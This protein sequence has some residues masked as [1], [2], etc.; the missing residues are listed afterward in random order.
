MFKNI[1]Y[2]K[3]I[4]ISFSSFII[5]LISVITLDKLYKSSLQEIQKVKFQY[6]ESKGLANDLLIYSEKVNSLANYYYIKKN[7]EHLRYFYILIR[8]F[9]NEEKLDFSLY[10]LYY[11]LNEG[12]ENIFSGSSYK[13]KDKLFS[14]DKISNQTRRYLINYYY[15]TYNYL[16]NIHN[17]VLS[18][19]YDNDSI[20]LH[21]HSRILKLD[22]L[23]LENFSNDSLSSNIDSL[24]T[25]IDSAGLVKQKIVVFDTI[26][27]SGSNSKINFIEKSISY[28]SS[29]FKNYDELISILNKLEQRDLQKL[30]LKVNY[31]ELGKSVLQWVLLFSFLI[32]GVFFYLSFG[33]IIQYFNKKIDNILLFSGIEN[34]IKLP[35]FTEIRSFVDKIS[36]IFQNQRFLNDALKDLQN[37]KKL[38]LTK[39]ELI[40]PKL[41]NGITNLS[42]NIALL[43]KESEDTLRLHKE[44][45]WINE[46]LAEF[47]EVLRT[48]IDYDDIDKSYF[49][50]LKSIIKLTKAN[51]GGLFIKNKD[52]DGEYLKLVSSYAYN[53]KRKQKRK[54]TAGDGI[55]GS[56]I[57]EKKPI[58]ID[59]L[60]K[61]YVYITSGIGEA[62]PKY[63]YIQPFTVGHEV[64]GAVELASFNQF[65]NYH[66]KFLVR[67]A[68]NLASVIA[69]LKG[70][71]EM[72]LL[73]RQSQSQSEALAIQ[74]EELRQNLEELQATQEEI[75]K[76]EREIHNFEDQINH[77]FLRAEVDLNTRFLTANPSFLKQFNIKFMQL[78]SLTVSNFLTRDLEEVFMIKWKNLLRK[79]SPFK[80]QGKLV[81]NNIKIEALVHFL[82]VLSEKDELKKVIILG[83]VIE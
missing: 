22:T 49:P 82:P 31:I 7:D 12:H 38:N 64:V 45:N 36:S 57:Y 34:K 43:T 27:T 77:S 54:I 47:N 15:S 48:E 68:E 76:K 19:N 79:N 60:P 1:S 5:L 3:I 37:Q 14:L 39:T 70:Q 8:K 30:T 52:E 62:T 35:F 26:Y 40:S 21:N 28:N 55:L 2:K 59:N 75:Q 56:I 69:S 81:Y 6:S 50:V 41:L 20:L 44:E 18:L 67:V 33:N 73:L 63:L 10:N 53:I 9:K 4:I 11:F 24:T 13:W 66:Q 17:A 42:S 25:N 83:S 16:V 78:N 32:W 23:K 71:D 58:Y 51:Q 61:D 29:L 65:L 72:K 80:I 74:E 46:A